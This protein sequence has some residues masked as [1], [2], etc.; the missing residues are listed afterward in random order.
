MPIG[1][2]FSSEEQFLL[3]KNGSNIN[4]TSESLHQIYV[5]GA[6]SEKSHLVYQQYY[7][8]TLSDVISA[9]SGLLSLM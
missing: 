5:T 7:D 2:P 1:I 4:G 9:C 6:L 3:I 8:T